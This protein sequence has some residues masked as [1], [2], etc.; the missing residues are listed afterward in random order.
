MS[1]VL[2]QAVTSVQHLSTNSALDISMEEVIDLDIVN[3]ENLMVLVT[4][5]M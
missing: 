1:L 4:S 5:K 2:L 3:D